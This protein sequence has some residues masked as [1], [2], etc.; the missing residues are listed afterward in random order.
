MRLLNKYKYYVTVAFCFGLIGLGAGLNLWFAPHIDVQA[1]PAFEHIAVRPF[2][3]AAIDDISSFNDKYL[4]TDGDS[5][6]IEISGIIG[7]ISTNMNNETV[8]LLNDESFKD[9]GV[10]CTLLEA[11]NLK[12]PEIGSKITLKGIV[13]S[14]AEYDEDLE[15]YIDAVLE[16]GKILN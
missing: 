1:N 7:E 9:A 13:R 8:I 10:L 14:G 3:K 2:I 6:I 12:I 5:K 11:N 16:E 15:L 4:A